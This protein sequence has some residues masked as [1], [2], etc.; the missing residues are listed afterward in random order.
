MA[1]FGGDSDETLA[2]ANA[3]VEHT[4]SEIARKESEAAC[5]DRP[6]AEHDCEP[7]LAEHERQALGELKVQL[8]SEIKAQRKDISRFER[9]G[10]APRPRPRTKPKT[11][12][13]SGQGRGRSAKPAPQILRRRGTAGG[14]GDRPGG[15]EAGPGDEPKARQ[16]GGTGSP[17]RCHACSAKLPTKRSNPRARRSAGRLPRPTPET[18]PKARQAG[19]TRSSAQCRVCSDSPARRNR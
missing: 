5:I 9:R 15:C 17:A 11:R 12:R 13:A 8:E 2:Q 7:Y 4:Q 1:K 6:T 18:K 14:R 19:G 3:R 10:R 16:A